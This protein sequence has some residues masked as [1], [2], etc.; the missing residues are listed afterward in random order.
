MGHGG[1]GGPVTTILLSWV[2]G[3]AEVLRQKTIYNEGAGK[4]PWRRM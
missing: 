2:M 4:R 3:A 1:E